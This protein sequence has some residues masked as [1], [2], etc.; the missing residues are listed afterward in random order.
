M[1][2]G[3][4]YEVWKG[5]GHPWVAW[6]KPVLLL[7]APGDAAGVVD[8]RHAYRAETAPWADLDTSWLPERAAVIIDLPAE[9]ALSLALALGQ[10]GLRP[11]LVING[12]TAPSELISMGGALEML[13]V[14]ARFATAFPIG[15]D[16]APALI[17]DARRNGDRLA[18]VPGCFDNRWAIFESDLPSAG[19]LRRVG[20]E[21]VVLVQHGTRPLGDVEAILR[22][23][24]AG[25]LELLVC[26]FDDPA[27]L[28]A[29]RVTPRGWLS[30]WASRVRRRLSFR[31]RGDG[32]FGHRVPIP[33]EPSHG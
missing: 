13:A 25:G 6:V 17:L 28:Y 22:R 3:E 18:V 1:N 24:H 15:P 20:V 29:V 26:D 32:S 10:R 19:D 9:S 27:P 8:E 23:Y 2:R 16:V 5:E 14:G 7:N 11:V 31:R 4:I 12:C 30:D 21:R 33:P